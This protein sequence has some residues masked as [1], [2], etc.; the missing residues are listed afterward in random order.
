M[1]TLI[2]IILKMH[3]NVVL[4]IHIL[5]FTLSHTLLV[6]YIEIEKG[7]CLLYTHRIM[8][9]LTYITFK[10]HRDFIVFLDCICINFRTF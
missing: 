4:I 6:K 1:Y 10:M 8:Y 9:T 2:D 7:K 3:W 5:L